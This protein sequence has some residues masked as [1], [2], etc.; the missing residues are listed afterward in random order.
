MKEKLAGGQVIGT[1][2]ATDADNRVEYRLIG[3]DAFDI[4]RYSGEIRTNRPLDRETTPTVELI[5]VAKGRLAASAMRVKVVV[6][7]V[8]DEA[9]VFGIR[10]NMT[11]VVS[12]DRPAGYPLLLAAAT[13]AD[14]LNRITYV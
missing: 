11:V 5:V 8:N 9:P 4:G 14:Y 13:D 7:D 12:R 6:E 2:S 10:A 3:S 1:L